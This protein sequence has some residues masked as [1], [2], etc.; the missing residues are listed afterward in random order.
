MWIPLSARTFVDC[1]ETLLCYKKKLLVTHGDI[2]VDTLSCPKKGADTPINFPSATYYCLDDK[3]NGPEAFD[4]LAKE[5]AT[6][7]KDCSLF[8]Q[9]HAVTQKRNDYLFYEL[10]C[11]YYKVQKKDMTKFNVGQFA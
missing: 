2:C 1:R 6:S 4:S 7:C 11:S 3:Y 8:V 5:L 9:K 10:Q